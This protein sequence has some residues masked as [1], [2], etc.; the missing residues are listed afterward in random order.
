MDPSPSTVTVS[1]V[2]GC[3]RG[4]DVCFAPGSCQRI[5]D[6]EDSK[7]F[8]CTDMFNVTMAV[9]LYLQCTVVV[10]RD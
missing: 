4:D 7:C 10:V 5:W 9:V 6:A 1:A 3:R 8:H 2:A